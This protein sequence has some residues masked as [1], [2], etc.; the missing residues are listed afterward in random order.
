LSNEEQLKLAE[1]YN[2]EYKSRNKESK[3]F[4]W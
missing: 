1:W 4:K 3:K 2:N